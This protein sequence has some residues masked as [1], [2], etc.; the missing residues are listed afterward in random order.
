MEVE[1]E[2]KEQLRQAGEE[3]GLDEKE[4]R[5]S[6]SEVDS[7][8]ST[9]TSTSESIISSEL[10]DENEVNIH[11]DDER[12][13]Y[14]QWKREL[15]EAAEAMGVAKEDLMSGSSIEASND[16]D[17]GTPDVK[18]A[19][20]MVNSNDS[21]VKI[22]GEEI[23]IDNEDID[24]SAQFS[25]DSSN[26]S[27]NQEQDVNEVIEIVDS[28]SVDDEKADD[29]YAY[30]NY[31]N[32]LKVDT[33]VKQYECTELSNTENG[34]SRMV[35]ESASPV[36][37]GRSVCV[38]LSAMNSTPIKVQENQSYAR[39]EVV[40]S[41][42]VDGGFMEESG[43]QGGDSSEYFN[44]SK[45]MLHCQSVDYPFLMYRREEMGSNAAVVVPFSSEKG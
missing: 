22:V 11:G 41:M 16:T 9:A 2:W 8:D 13:F 33:S 27:T 37:N 42:E 25:S 19:N 40:A 38:K 4:F 17:D 31:G 24:C 18:E 32:G 28:N 44:S 15:K 30:S 5:S 34:F 20:E 1:D 7:D 14:Q 39:A 21:E 6:E 12:E 35:L 36:K 23:I 29:Q 26:D 43:Q 10:E 3:M 45:Y